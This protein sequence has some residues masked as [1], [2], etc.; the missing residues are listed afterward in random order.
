MENEERDMQEKVKKETKKIINDILE[1]GI[2]SDNIDFLG[3]VV[4]IHKDIS[5]EEYWKDKEEVYDMRYRTSGR[6]MYDDGRYGDHMSENYGRGRRRD[7]RGR[8][9]G[10][11]GYSKHRGDDM[12]DE[13]YRRY[14]DYNDGKDQYNRG[15]YGAKDD[16][17]ESLECMMEA[18]VDFIEALKKD[19]D[20]EELDIIRKYSRKISEM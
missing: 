12:I 10:R 17:I 7:S 11:D 2:H 13:M 18:V 14:E 9:M 1:D 4:D 16:T 15:N 6:D 5:N 8:Y 19:A 3:K 20:Q